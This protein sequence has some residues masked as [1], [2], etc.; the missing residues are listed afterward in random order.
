MAKRARGGPGA[1][2]PAA[3]AANAGDRLVDA[4]LAL[5]AR[6]GWRD[7]GMAEIARE[8]G[9]TLADAHAACPSKLALLAGLHRRID[10]AALA[11]AG[12]SGEEAQ[13]DRLFDLLMRRFDALQPHKA[14]LRSILRGSI[15]DAGM[16]LGVPALLSSLAWRLEA[17][18]IPATGWRGRLRVHLLAALYISVFRTFLE[19][20]SADLARTMAALD[21]RLRRAESW[22]GMAGT[23][24]EA[25]A[26]AER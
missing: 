6:Q 13:R 1:A 5:A 9:L 25:A 2:K 4:A 8:A 16:L 3:A 23:A 24:T 10:Q 22:L 21:Q 19:D 14:A 20:D 11:E 7:T 15:G 18:D 12:A 17:A 26:A